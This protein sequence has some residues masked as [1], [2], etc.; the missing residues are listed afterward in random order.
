[1]VAPRPRS[2]ISK[3][4]VPLLVASLL[5]IAMPAYGEDPGHGSARRPWG[6]P[7]CTPR[8]ELR[9]VVDDA[10]AAA[11]A[12]DIAGNGRG[13]GAPGYSVALS[14]HGCGVFLY[15]VG[16]RDV[17]RGK[18]MNR[19]TLHHLGSLTKVL[20]G[21]LAIRLA[22]AGAFGPQGLEATVDQFFSAGEIDRLSFGDDPENPLCPADILAV[23]R[24][25]G[26]LEPAVGLCPDFSFIT[27]RHL[28]NGNSGLYDFYNEVDRNFNGIPDAGEPPLGELFDALGVPRQV[29]PEGTETAFDFL[30]LNGVLASPSATPGGTS[31]ADF[32]LTFGTTGHTLFGFIAERVTGR[33]YNRLLRQAITAPLR[34]FR[35]LSLTAPPNPEGLISRQYLVTSGADQVGLPEDL[36]GIY[37]Q[38]DVAGNPAINVYQL[39]S[40]LATAGG[41]AAGSVVATTGS[42]RTFFDA[43]ATGRWLNA[44]ERALFDGSFVPI[45]EMPGVFHGFGVFR[46]DDPE[47]GPGFAKSGRVTGSACQLLHFAEPGSTV[48]ACRN[49]FDAFLGPPAP[50]TSTPIGDLARELIRVAGP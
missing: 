13:S 22:V 25:T 4:L 26:A 44:A 41:G 38:V 9:R 2:G 24:V 18:P 11:P 47:F 5:V 28:L 8:A 27:L 42:Y 39:G 12:A 16:L 17:E 40:F 29:L 50:P 14:K 6:G 48:V 33:T 46:F 23:N 3:T 15:G 30:V 1:M 31:Q 36:F 49:S 19:R 7:D 34:T 37:P 32:E 20:T 21:T 10:F 45:T 35:M 43:V